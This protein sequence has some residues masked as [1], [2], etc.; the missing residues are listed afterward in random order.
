MLSAVAM[1]FWIWSDPY[2]CY[3]ASQ[4]ETIRVYSAY[5]YFLCCLFSLPWLIS[6]GSLRI[7]PL[8]PSML[9]KPIKHSATG[10]AEG[11]CRDQ[12]P[13]L[14]CLMVA[15]QNKGQCSIA[16]CKETYSELNYGLVKQGFSTSIFTA[17]LLQQQ[18]LQFIYFHCS[19]QLTTS[20][21]LP[22]EGATENQ[23]HN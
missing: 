8:F 16:M 5:C 19:S 2:S 15:A 12:I 11:A 20:L 14:W 3:F 9:C 6:A 17:R 1:S 10:E 22:W 21:L 4:L 7:V 23:N 13:N 18:L